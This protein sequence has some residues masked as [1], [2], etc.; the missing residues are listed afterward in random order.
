M[1]P[2]TGASSLRRRR[3]EKRVQ[4]PNN[5]N[6]WVRGR[7]LQIR[8]GQMGRGQIKTRRN[9]TRAVLRWSPARVCT[10]RHVKVPKFDCRLAERL[11][12]PVRTAPTCAKIDRHQHDKAGCA[13]LAASEPSTYPD[14]PLSQVRTVTPTPRLRLVCATFRSPGRVGIPAR[15]ALQHNLHVTRCL[16]Q[17]CVLFC[18][19]TRHTAA[20]SRLRF[21]ESTHSNLSDTIITDFSCR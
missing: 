6:E 18:K 21:R 19:H 14:P 3:V 1:P 15:Q 7:D 8:K 13:S 4:Q 5:R 9:R 10:G 17:V 2:P 11:C 20:W 12:C 16:F